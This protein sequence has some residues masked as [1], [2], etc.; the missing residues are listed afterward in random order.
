MK[1]RSLFA[2]VL[3]TASI[4][5]A[6]PALL[7]G[8]ASVTALRLAPHDAGAELT[9]YM[10]GSPE[11]WSDFEL[12]GP[13]RVIVDLY[14]ARSDLPRA[15][16]DDINR[17]GVRSVRTSQF[18]RGVVRVVI[19]LDATRRYTV[20][21]T[22]EGI[23]VT[24]EGDGD[25]SPWA[26]RPDLVRAPRAAAAEAPRTPPPVARVAGLARARQPER[27]TV[28]FHDADIRDVIAS[29]AEFTGRSI[30][31]GRGVAGIPVTADIRDQP[32]DVALQTI[33]HAY[34]LAAEEL[35][36]GIIRVDSVEELRGLREQ[37]APVTQSFRINYVPVQELAL[38][39]D[40]M[41]T[42]RGSISVNPSTNTLIVTDVESVVDRIGAMIGQLDVQTPQVAIRAKIIVVNRTRAQQLGF[43][44]ALGTQLETTGVGSARAGAGEISLQG[45]GVTNLGDAR[46]RLGR[47]V[48]DF[49]IPLVTSLADFGVFI[50]AAQDLSLSDLQAAPL[51]TALDNQQAE[52]FVGE[53]TPIRVVDLGAPGTIGPGARATAQLVETGIRLLVTPHITTDRQIMLELQAENSSA[54]RTPDEIGVQFLR[55]RGVTRLL[56]DDG[57]TAVIGGLSRT[58]VTE[59]RSGI[60]ILM[61]IPVLGALFRHTLSAEEQV[62]LIIMVTP[63]IIDARVP[64]TAPPE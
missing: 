21:R 7:S 42:E 31:P 13:P 37:E 15:R 35:P 55:Q 39:L 22:A 14:G 34:G 30:V 61:D 19:D 50:E 9:I 40:P 36:S 32:W 24:L 8:Q 33:L 11:E 1:I 45:P 23:T 59:S 49:T 51:I 58:I 54:Q 47:D 6:T 52:I 4:G 25:F 5:G 43:R 64:L 2:A 63:R 46:V 56:V 16:F 29:F 57:E 10:T 28:A 3:V 44:Y 20:A 12:P 62:D 26:S 38:A 53:E 27:I 18:D 17:G 60:P 41:R 48:L